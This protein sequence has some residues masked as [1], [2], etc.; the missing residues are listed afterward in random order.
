MS[1]DFSPQDDVITENL[2]TRF[3]SYF[4]LILSCANFPITSQLINIS[5]APMMGSALCQGSCVVK[6]MSFLPSR[7]SVGWNIT[8]QTKRSPAGFRPGH[9]SRLQVQSRLGH[10]RDNR[11]MFLSLSGIY[12][13]IYLKYV[14]LKIG[15]NGLMSLTVDSTLCLINGRGSYKHP[16]EKYAQAE[17]G[18]CRVPPPQ[19]RKTTSGNRRLQLSDSSDA[20][21]KKWLGFEQG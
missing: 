10:V 3:F 1:L 4:L 13:Y 12:I 6:I 16:L 15:E 7:C 19:E 21:P 8:P 2:L 17:E 11:L 5:R 9:A 18:T 20:G 14:Y